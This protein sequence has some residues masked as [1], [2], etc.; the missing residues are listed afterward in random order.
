[1][2]W[3]DEFS[4]GIQE[5]DEQHK[6]MLR[7]FTE[8]LDALRSGEI[9]SVTYYAIVSATDRARTHFAFEEALMRMFGYARDDNHLR[10]HNEFFQKLQSI[11]RHSINDSAEDEMLEFLSYWLKQHILEA[12]KGYVDHLLHGASIV[13]SAGS[14]NAVP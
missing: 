2:E 8:I 7:S 3:H 10:L 9:W 6:A 5:I 14:M 12:D 4:L 13:R 11:K 1:M